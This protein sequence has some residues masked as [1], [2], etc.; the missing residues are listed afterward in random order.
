[1]RLT[2]HVM[3]CSIRP[4]H[5]NI[6]RTSAQRGPPAR[7]ASVLTRADAAGIAIRVGLQEK[8]VAKYYRALFVLTF[9][10]T[11]QFAAPAAAQ[12]D[13]VLD[14]N[15]RAVNTAIAN[16]QNPFAQARTGAIVQLAVRSCQRDHGRL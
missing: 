1:M 3:G 13:V 11:L 4:S 16:G 9:V 7:V 8:L 10:G 2:S 14:W 6:P 15:E 12:Q 5:R